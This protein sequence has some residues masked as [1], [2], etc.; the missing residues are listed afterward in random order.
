[1]TDFDGGA[2]APADG[3][4]VSSHE[5]SVPIQENAPR[6]QEL[7]SQTP[8]AEKPAPAAEPKPDAKPE[9]SK[10]NREALEKAFNEAKA[11]KEAD[12]PAPQP[13]QEAQREPQ[14]AESARDE[15]G[16]F[17][18]KE[19]AQQAPEARQQTTQNPGQQTTSNSPHAT[20]PSRFDDAAKGEWEKAPESIKGAI[21]RTI[22]ELEQGHQKYRADAEE[23]E[24]VRKFSDMAKQSGTTL[25]KALEQYVELETGMKQNPIG[26]MERI[27]QMHG[28]SMRQ[29]AEHIMGQTPDQQA[30]Q[31]DQEII[32]LR[33][34][35]ADVQKQLGGVT[36]TFQKQQNDQTL[37]QVQAFAAQHPRFD[38][39]AD[40]ISKE[41]QHGYSLEEAYDR[42]DR[43]NPAANPKPLIPA[44]ISAP[45]QTRTEG[46]PNPAGQKSISGAPSS[47]SDPTR[48]AAPSQNNREAL[49][50]AFAK[51]GL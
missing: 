31:R 44:D 36:E 21:H 33:Q 26:T 28:F 35:L 18:P 9:P 3:G 37:S 22:R 41:I 12:K 8:V 48:S 1:M 13:K 16:R 47:G 51:Q 11:K 50:K 6:T 43:L 27:A 23:F 40:A 49:R 20:A 32:S 25:N 38:E 4:S 46:Q 39:L 17:A 19:G 2:G 34:Q 14:K 10:S 24:S 7:G 5:S 42:A 30:S 29:V 15:G 45:A